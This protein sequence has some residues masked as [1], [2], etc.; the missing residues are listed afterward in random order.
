MV[1]EGRGDRTV[2][3]EGSGVTGEDEE[4]GLEVFVG[5]GL[6]LEADVF[7]GVVVRVATG[8]VF[9][10]VAEEV[11]GGGEVAEEVGAAGVVE[12]AG[13]AVDVV[14][15]DV[16]V[17]VVVEGKKA[18]F[19][20]RSQRRCQ[21][22]RYLVVRIITPAIGDSISCIDITTRSGFFP[23]SPPPASFPPSSF[24]PSSFPLL[25]SGNPAS[26]PL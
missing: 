18:A 9:V 12:A 6:V 2:S 26:P 11:E 24:P 21:S 23:T 3:S 16:D 13:V 20:A 4:G 8:A 7:N 19:K 15:L 25:P 17:D 5:G 14:E 22:F 1:E 10:S